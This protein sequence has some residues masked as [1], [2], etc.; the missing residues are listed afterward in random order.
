[1]PD[2][3]PADPAADEAAATPPKMD[4][5]LMDAAMSSDPAA[6]S[7]AVYARLK[8]VGKGDTRGDVNVPKRFGKQKSIQVNLNPARQLEFSLDWIFTDD[9]TQESVYDIAARDRHRPA[10]L[11]R[12]DSRLRTDGR[13]Q[14]ALDVRSG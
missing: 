11:Q 3:P 6:E 7:V 12:D 2:E 13:G 8:P 1:M 5:S 4:T 9:D 14:D 10:R